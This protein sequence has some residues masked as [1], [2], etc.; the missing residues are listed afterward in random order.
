[1]RVVKFASVG[2]LNT[3]IDFAV[4]NLLVLVFGVGIVVANLVSYS[5]GI[6]N[7]YLWNRNWTFADRR[8][9][10]WRPELFKFVVAN[11]GGLAV[12]TGLVWLLVRAL[13]LVTRSSDTATSTWI[14]PAAKAAAI[15]GTM[16]FNYIAFK[17]WVFGSD[18]NAE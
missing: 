6:A 10:R 8:S 2:A 3:V 16:V 13:E 7:S 1:M 15:A 17:F 4:F 12:N 11:L 14:P 5:A 18:P 9:N